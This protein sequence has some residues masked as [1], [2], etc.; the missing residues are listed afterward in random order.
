MTQII[1]YS[2]PLGNR[3]SMRKIKFKLFYVKYQVLEQVIMLHVTNTMLKD[4]GTMEFF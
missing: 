4:G 2:L 3:I 1:N